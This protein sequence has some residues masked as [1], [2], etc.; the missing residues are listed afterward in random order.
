MR[1]LGDSAAHAKPAHPPRDEPGT[2]PDLAW[3]IYSSA[4]LYE[5]CVPAGSGAP[6]PPLRSDD[7]FSSRL[8]PNK[9][10]R[11]IRSLTAPTSQGRSAR[12]AGRPLAAGQALASSTTNAF[13]WPPSSRGGER[14]AL[15]LHDHSLLMCRRGRDAARRRAGGVGAA[16]EL[17]EAYTTATELNTQRRARAAGGAGARPLSSRSPAPAN[18][19]GCGAGRSAEFRRR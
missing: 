18:R 1:G 12:G 6:R 2:P 15:L 13:R 19:R 8:F 3:I 7:P 4:V 5:Q 17:R 16:G 9:S 11:A 14:R 10:T